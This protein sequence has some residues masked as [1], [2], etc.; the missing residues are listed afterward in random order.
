MVIIFSLLKLI[1]ISAIYLSLVIIS[2]SIIIFLTNWSEV[3]L[4]LINLLNFFLD[5]VV[6]ILSISWFSDMSI[7]SS[8]INFFDSDT[9]ELLTL[10]LKKFPSNKSFEKDSW[11][12]R[13]VKNVIEITKIFFIFIINHF[14]C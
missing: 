14:F 13:K 4:S 7:I 1:F 8:I 11:E 5:Y 6:N 3:K 9:L 2:L 12:T 10:M